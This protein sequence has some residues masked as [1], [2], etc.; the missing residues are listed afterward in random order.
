MSSK[1]VIKHTMMLSRLSNMNKMTIKLRIEDVDAA[2]MDMDFIHD[3]GTAIE[4]DMKKRCNDG[5]HR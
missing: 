2:T 5:N 3:R 4:M 1:T